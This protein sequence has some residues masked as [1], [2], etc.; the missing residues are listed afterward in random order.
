[1]I[2]RKRRV[3]RG[4]LVSMIRSGTADRQV[5]LDEMMKKDEEGKRGTSTYVGKIEYTW[6]SEFM[7]STRGCKGQVTP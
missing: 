4:L 1:M 2:T 7:M 5:Q 6:T 3:K